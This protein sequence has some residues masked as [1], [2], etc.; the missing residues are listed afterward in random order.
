MNLQR[1][2]EYAVQRRH[3]H[4]LVHQAKGKETPLKSLSFLPQRDC[5]TIQNA[6]EAN[7]SSS[8]TT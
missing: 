1:M 5:A 4:K 6:F 8:T 3:P 2:N 7:E